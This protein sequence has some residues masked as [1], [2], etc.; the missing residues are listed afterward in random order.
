MRIQLHHVGILTPD[1]EGTAEFYQEM[2]GMQVTVPF[3]EE[4]Y[5]KGLFLIDRTDR[6][7]QGIELVG[8]PFVGWRG[9]MFDRYGPRWDHLSF[10][11]DDFDSWYERIREMGVEIISPPMEWEGGKEVAFRDACGVVAQLVQIHNSDS[12]FKPEDKTSF[13]SEFEYRLHHFSIVSDELL[14]LERFYRENFGQ[15]TIYDLKKEGIVFMSDPISLADKGRDAP[16]IEIIAPPGLGER[17]QAFLDEHGTGIDHICFMVSNVD[18]AYEEL[19]SKGAKFH[20]EPTNFEGTRLAFFKDLNGVD[21][22]IE[23]PNLTHEFDV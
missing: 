15:K 8:P 1:V 21:I 18:G 2:L 16:A 19:K 7:G 4:E 17:E 23:L 12:I 11:V 5:L 10:I 3:Y 22:E 14:S 6:P 20:V 9:K 13:E